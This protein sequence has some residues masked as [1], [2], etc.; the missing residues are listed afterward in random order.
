MGKTI[1]LFAFIA[2]LLAGSAVQAQDGVATGTTS[3]LNFIVLQQQ[4]DIL[5]TTINSLEAELVTYQS[6]DAQGKIFS[7]SQPDADANGCYVPEVKRG[8]SSRIGNLISD[9]LSHDDTF[10]VTDLVNDSDIASVTDEPFYITF[11]VVDLD[12]NVV[13]QVA[14][15][16][17][18]DTYGIDANSNTENEVYIHK[19]DQLSNGDFKVIIADCIP[20][21]GV[22]GACDRRVKNIAL[23]Q[24]N[25]VLR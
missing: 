5:Q 15:Y 16:F 19:S 12:G 24:S 7:P 3:S 4:I 9:T 8:P 21:M 23:K 18:N 6:C 2:S 20:N 11:D 22:A 14:N 17:E 25:Y 1:T 13:E 10:T